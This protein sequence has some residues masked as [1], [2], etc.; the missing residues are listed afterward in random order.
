[1][2]AKYNNFGNQQQRAAM[3]S[4]SKPSF[5]LLVFALL[6]V[7]VDKLGFCDGVWG[8]EE[9]EGVDCEAVEESSDE[10]DKTSG[11]HGSGRSGGVRH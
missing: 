9:E 2:K 6:G 5:S 10:E 8:V 7:Q 4:S 1:M 11:H 3:I